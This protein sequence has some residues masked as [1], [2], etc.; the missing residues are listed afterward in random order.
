MGQPLGRGGLRDKLRV[1]M[2]S[3]EPFL[4]FQVPQ[5]P[6]NP[7]LSTSSAWARLASSVF[8]KHSLF[9]HLCGLGLSLCSF[10]PSFFIE[11]LYPIQMPSSEFLWQPNY[12]PTPQRYHSPFCDLLKGMGHLLPNIRVLDVHSWCAGCFSH[13]VRRSQREIPGWENGFVLIDYPVFLLFPLWEKRVY[14]LSLELLWHQLC[15]WNSCW[16][17]LWPLFK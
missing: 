13:G 12:T 2:W 14:E 7:S 8:P 4:S 17:T 5:Y 16:A 11:V 9:S 1:W 6:G 15:K 3:T 10:F